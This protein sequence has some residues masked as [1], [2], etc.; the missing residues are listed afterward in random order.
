MKMQIKNS[1]VYDYGQQCG[2]SEGETVYLD[3][4]FNK[5]AGKQGSLRG[6]Q[7]DQIG[8]A[9]TIFAQGTSFVPPASQDQAWP[10]ID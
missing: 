3:G 5:H 1:A 6:G 8:A 7:I 9:R 10:D 2:M 4:S